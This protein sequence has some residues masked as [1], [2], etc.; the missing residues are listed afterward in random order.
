MMR[1]DTVLIV[2][3]EEDIHA[4]GVQAVLQRSGIRVVRVD[5]ADFPTTLG[6]ILEWSSTHVSKLI[7]A[8]GTEMTRDEITAV[9]WRRPRSF[10]IDAAVIDAR[11]REFGRLNAVHAFEALVTTLPARV[12]NDLWMERRALRKGLQLEIAS[13]C[14]LRIPYTI[15]SNDAA[16]IRA[17]AAA[18]PRMIYKP[19]EKINGAAD[20]TKMLELEDIPRLTQLRH[21]PAIFQEFI[22]PGYDLRIYIIGDTIYSAKLTSDHPSGR[23]DIRMDFSAHIEP[24]VLPEPLQMALFRMMKTLGL[25][26]GAIDMKV[27]V[28]GNYFFLEVNPSGQWIYIEMETGQPITETLAA[29]LAGH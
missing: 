8:D 12:V 7:L 28:D 2:A 29:Y 24:Y 1:A 19:L 25:V 13:Q 14:G 16:V 4:Q 21:G 27:D 9:W 15:I 6:L 20:G 22:E 5:T 23:V 3:P 18:R 17:V 26:S 11:D 10:R